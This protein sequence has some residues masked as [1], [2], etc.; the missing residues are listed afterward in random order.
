MS[1]NH[2]LTAVLRRPLFIVKPAGIAY[3]CNQNQARMTADWMV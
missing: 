1:M 2:R 3:I